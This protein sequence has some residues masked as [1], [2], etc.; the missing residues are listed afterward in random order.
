MENGSS[1]SYTPE[2]KT[3]RLLLGYVLISNFL[4]WI[5]FALYFLIRQLLPVNSYGIFSLSIRTIVSINLFL[6]SLSTVILYMFIKKKHADKFD[7]IWKKTNQA[8]CSFFY[9][10]LNYKNCTNCD[11]W[12]FCL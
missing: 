8:I 7:I 2:P 3:L 4:H 9:N 1:Y 12:I 10:L 6:S 5:I 11:I